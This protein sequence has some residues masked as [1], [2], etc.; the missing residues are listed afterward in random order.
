MI[1]III[2]RTLVFSICI[3]LL[4][5]GIIPTISSIRNIKYDNEEKQINIESVIQVTESKLI[6]L[7]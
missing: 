4:C 5:S 2:K 6:E 3:L 1:N 7:K